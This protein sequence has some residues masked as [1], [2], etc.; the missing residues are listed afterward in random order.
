LVRLYR[1]NAINQMVGKEYHEIAVDY[2]KIKAKELLDS[3]SASLLRAAHHIIAA[4][5]SVDAISLLEPRAAQII[6]DGEAWA[7]QRTLNEID[8]ENVSTLC[9][10]QAQIMKGAVA[11]HLGQ[12]AKS[13]ELYTAA[14]KTAEAL[15]D[16]NLQAQTLEGLGNAYT[17]SGQPNSADLALTQL[18]KCRD[19]RVIT[20]DQAG[21]AETYRLIGMVY[22]R[23]QAFQEA[24]EQLGNAL[25]LA[26]KLRTDP[27]NTTMTPLEAKIQFGRG[28]V[29]M[30]S[31]S[32][33]Q[34]DLAEAQKL[35]EKC[36]LAFNDQGNQRRK[37]QA[38]G[39]LALLS[40]RLGDAAGQLQ[41]YLEMIEIQIR[42]S[43]FAGQRV[44]Y[45]NLGSL[46]VTR[47]QYSDALET[48]QKLLDLA[49]RTGHL[50]FECFALAGMADAKRELGQIAEAL[51]D[52][53]SALACAKRINPLQPPSG[54]LGIG[55]R[56]LGEVQFSN[57]QTADAR[58][59]LERAVKLLTDRGQEFEADLRRASLALEQIKTN[60]EIQ[61]KVVETLFSCGA[62]TITKTCS[63]RASTDDLL[64]MV[65]IP[66]AYLVKSVSIPAG[67]PLTWIKDGI[68]R[69]IRRVIINLV[70]TDAGGTVLEQFPQP[71]KLRIVAPDANTGSAVSAAKIIP[72]LSNPKT[73]PT[74]LKWTGQLWKP[75]PEL[76]GSVLG[77]E[78]EI[79][80][81]GDPPIA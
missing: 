26:Q 8:I 24:K 35:F 38:I 78:F 19:L 32:G 21:V 62:G 61:D 45:N 6:D 3:A 4:E 64:E 77:R 73:P 25:E 74:L 36:R 16:R 31:A 29:L 44:T 33:N 80:D 22:Y 79:N 2:Y 43:D 48:Y 10:V 34:Q 81:W 42:I 69:E 40:E 1:Q 20:G 65:D 15:E 55:W 66:A 72:I 59:S 63:F 9:K 39:N 52:A 5:R 67:L 47:N 41:A 17:R 56:A 68:E 70:I 58:A 13:I 60:P 54:E 46:F 18:Q 23:K 50:T 12:Y 27:N 37:A 14:N 71:L 57:H 53:Q 51:T 30:N 11:D 28:T 49:N 75:I 7:F 76:D